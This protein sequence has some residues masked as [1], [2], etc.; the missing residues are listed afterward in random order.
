M[1]YLEIESDV[2]IDIAKDLNK[3][4][5]TRSGT[6]RHLHTLQTRRM[7]MGYGLHWWEDVWAA[8]HRSQG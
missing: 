2:V 4:D 3:Q 7:S 1:V 6:F 8:R 5:Q